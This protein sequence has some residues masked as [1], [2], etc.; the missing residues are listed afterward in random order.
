[1]LGPSDSGCRFRAGAA[2]FLRE[3]PVTMAL[4]AEVSFAMNA[5]RYEPAEPNH[6]MNDF[7]KRSE[8][9]VCS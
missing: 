9:A 2:G 7:T 1:M 3:E 4:V 5:G 8:Q 6:P